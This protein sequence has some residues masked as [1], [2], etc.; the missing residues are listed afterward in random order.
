MYC[1]QAARTSASVVL[2]TS[3]CFLAQCAPPSAAVP[4]GIED[5]LNGIHASSLRDDLKFIASDELEGRDS[6]SKGLDRAADY[7]ADQFRRAGLEPAVGDSYFQTASMIL[8]QPDF[9]HFELN[10]AS[11]RSRFQAKPSDV[12]F[13]FSNALDLTNAPLFKLD[14]ADA[15]QL[16]HLTKEQVQ[17]KVVMAAF[18]RRL[19]RRL[20]AA[21]P[22]LRSGAPALVILVDRKGMT[23]EY[24]RNRRL[25]DPAQPP[26][27]TRQPRVFV[28]GDR[29]ADFWE[30]LKPGTGATATF[31][32]APLRTPATLRNVIGVLRGSDPALRSTAVLLTAHYDHLGMKPEGPGDRIYNGANDNG[33]GTVSVME[34]ARALARLPRHPRRSIVFMTFFGE[35]E[36]LIGSHYY[37]QHPVWPLAKTIADLNLEQVGRTDSS[38]G[39]EFSNASLT[40][41]DYS[42]LTRFVQDAGKSTGIKVYKDPQGSDPYFQDSDNFSLAEVG[43]PAETL[44]V[45]FQFPDY[46]AVGDEWQKIDYDNMAKVDRAIALS[47]FLMADSEQ[48]VRWNESNPKTAPYV[49][50]A[51][52]LK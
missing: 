26:S 33:S 12:F 39:P 46:H 7:I 47:M 42:G 29:V 15:G 5:A 40:G 21:E 11:G 6:P 22:V 9:P 45:A 36:G 43:V 17:G 10:F 52:Q 13:D 18:D 25:I 37:A 38:E 3:L 24:R 16:Q 2:L 14:L 34:V 23:T 30:A 31:H 35:E 1:P 50:A 20:E 32:F 27:K 41:F 8:E 4:P 28:A 19:M 48:A 44:C 49:K 51:K